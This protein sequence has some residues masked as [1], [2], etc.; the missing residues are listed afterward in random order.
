MSYIVTSETYVKVCT[1][2]MADRNR[3]L[4]E[5]KAMLYQLLQRLQLIRHPS[6]FIQTVKLEFGGRHLKETVYTLFKTPTGFRTIL[7]TSNN[8]SWNFELLRNFAGNLHCYRHIFF[9][10]L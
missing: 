3:C 2:I 9:R 1:Q 8:F 10:I 5:K 7:P 4:V 6:H